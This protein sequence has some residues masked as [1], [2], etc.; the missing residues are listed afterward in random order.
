M[1]KKKSS[2]LLVYAA[3]IPG[4]LALALAA[5]NTRSLGSA[6]ARV[7][8]TAS[9][10]AEADEAGRRIDPATKS[11]PTAG[12]KPAAKKEAAP[13]RRARFVWPVRGWVTSHYGKRASGF[14]HGMDIACRWGSKILAARGGRVVL[15]KHDFWYGKMLVIGN[16]KGYNTL[17][18]HMNSVKAKQ[19]QVVHQG[20]VIGTCG[21]TGNSFG[22]H[23]HFEIRR[24]GLY[25]DPRKHLP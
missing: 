17:Y 24:N 4:T 20:D 6:P 13:K 9:P 2:L 25:V 23:L 15:R 5:S 16:L 3:V 7:S 8:V 19:G 21:N 10:S 22:N 14:H 12:S 18:G 11:V 1:F